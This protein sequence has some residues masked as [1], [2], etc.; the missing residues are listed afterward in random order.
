MLAR[1]LLI[2]GLVTALLC[3]DQP[4]EAWRLG[5]TQSAA[6]NCPTYNTTE[7]TVRAAVVSATGQVTCGPLSDANLT[8]AVG[9]G[10]NPYSTTGASFNGQI[11]AGFL[12]VNSLITPA[13]FMLAPGQMLFDANSG[14]N[15]PGGT[16]GSTL[17]ITGP[18]DGTP[19][20]V[21]N[22]AISN[23]SLTVAAET[24]WALNV[25]TLKPPS[26]I[27]IRE[28]AE[29][30]ACQNGKTFITNISGVLPNNDLST[31]LTVW[32]SVLLTSESIAGGN[33]QSA[34]WNNGQI[35]AVALAK[36]P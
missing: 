33:P 3:R 1:F 25:A 26:S 34:S 7:F 19:G 36:Y 11:A 6:V 31:K 22:Y 24:M 17:T 27:Q 28:S 15:I 18:S 13:S 16:T 30:L 4:A 5:N 20:G 23:G 2:V 14:S 12:T 21:G 32:A 35:T 8:L 9:T 10:V 29:H